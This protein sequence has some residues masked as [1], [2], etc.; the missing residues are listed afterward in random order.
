MTT[1][2]QFPSTLKIIGFLLHTRIFP[3][4]SGKRG[5]GKLKEGTGDSTTVG[6][7][8]DS[9]CSCE[10]TTSRRWMEMHV[11][12]NIFLVQSIQGQSLWRDLNS[13][14]ELSVIV[15]VPY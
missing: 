5:A 9:P 15:D 3:W 14:S 13:L 11:D 7:G 2:P 12:L 6:R 4:S 8:V 10:F 1:V